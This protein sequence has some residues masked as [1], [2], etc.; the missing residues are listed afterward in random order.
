MMRQDDVAFGVMLVLILLVGVWSGIQYVY[1]FQHPYLTR[2]QV[3]FWS[4][5]LE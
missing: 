5:G 4:L 2:M 3:L 1:W